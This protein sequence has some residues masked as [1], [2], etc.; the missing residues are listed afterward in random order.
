MPLDIREL[1]VNSYITTELEKTS[2]E[3]HVDLCAMRYQQLDTR[4]NLIEIKVS[5]LGKAIE[6]SKNSMAKIII[7]STATIVS[8][9]IGVIITI[10]MKF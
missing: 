5:D 1:N 7:A 10:L 3:A 6:E 9:L 4:L 2:L 8:S